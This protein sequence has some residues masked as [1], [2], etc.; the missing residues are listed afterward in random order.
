MNNTDLLV[1]QTRYAIDSGQSAYVK[2]VYYQPDVNVLASIH[3]AQQC[4]HGAAVVNADPD[5]EVL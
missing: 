3:H 4:Q 2:T 5:T 1:Y